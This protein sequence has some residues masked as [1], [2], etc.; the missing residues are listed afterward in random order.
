MSSERDRPPIYAS[1][2]LWGAV[3]VVTTVGG[4]TDGLWT[5]VALLLGS[6]V[7]VAVVTLLA[8]GLGRLRDAG[9]SQYDNKLDPWDD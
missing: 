7:G 3:A 9:G 1:P 8:N 2:L 5:A 6:L 4:V